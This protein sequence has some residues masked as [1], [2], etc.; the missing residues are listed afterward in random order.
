MTDP[1]KPAEATT[2]EVS[3]D[4][5]YNTWLAERGTEPDES[6][7]AATEPEAPEAE[8]AEEPE[9]SDEETPE[10]EAEKK[11]DEPEEPETE[12]PKKGGVQKRIDKLTREKRELED[13]LRAVEAEKAKPAEPAK[14]AAVEGKP[15]VEDSDTYEEYIEKLTDW[16]LAEHVKTVKADEQKRQV[17]VEQKARA[18][19]WKSQYAAV[20]ALPEFAD[21]DEVL[22]DADDITLPN[23]VQDLL[24]ESGP[25]TVYWLAKHKEEAARIGSLS[26]T[27]AARAI[28]KIEGSLDAPSTPT[29]AAKPQQPKVTAAPK[30]ITP[31]SGGKAPAT[32]EADPS[33][34]NAWAKK[35]EEQLRKR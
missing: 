30:P 18:D 3:A 5:N 23:Y 25:K 15:K 27:A 6:A 28:G 35:R 26:P 4:E 20:K 8:T 21:Y 14:P 13:R 34:Y 32:N 1:T 10:V 31:V 24:F 9:P 7:S 16:K 19:S 2:D 22:A 33:D 29:P 12:A 11:E 17:A